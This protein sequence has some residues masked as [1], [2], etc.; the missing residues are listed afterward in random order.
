[1]T[2]NIELEFDHHTAHLIFDRKESSA[3][4][5]DAA[6]LEE[7]NERLT[8]IEE[9]KECDGLI[10][11][12]RKPNIFIAG[13]DLHSLQNTELKDLSELISLGQ[14]TFNRIA[15]LPFPTVAA[16][17]GACVGGGCELALAC[18]WRVATETKATKIGLPETQLGIIPAWGGTTRLPRLIG[19]PKALSIILPGKI[20]KAKAAKAK[21]LVDF[22]VPKERLKDFAIKLLKKDRIDRNQHTLTN[23]VIS[24]NI[25]EKKAKDDLLLK[26]KG[27]YPAQEEALHAAC[28]GIHLTRDESLHLERLAIE[29]LA[30]SETANNLMRIFFL[31][32]GSKKLRIGETKVKECHTPAVIGA[33]VMGSGIA[34]WLTSKG[35]PTLMKDVSLQALAKGEHTVEKLYQA[36]RKRRV[37]NKTEAQQGID[38][39]KTTHCEVPLK[40]YDL[41]I[42]AATEDLPIK[43]KIFENLS[44]KVSED[45]LLATN[46]SALP[47]HGLIDSVHNPERLVGLHFFNPVHRMQLVEVVKTKHVSDEFLAKAVNFVQKIGKLPVVVADSP[48]FLVNRVLLP[49]L[50]EAG[51]MFSRGIKP[52]FIDEAMLEFGMP[53]GPLRLLDEIGLDVAHHVAGTLSQAFPDRMSVPDILEQMIG[54][55]MLG[56]K[57]GSGFYTY[58]KGQQPSPNPKA[59]ELR[60]SDIEAPDNIGITLARLMALEASHCLDEGIVERPEDVDF[61]MIMGTGFAPFRGGPLRYAHDHGVLGRKFYKD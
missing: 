4:I 24:S 44:K 20:L 54:L 9:N 49:Y 15:E 28:Q 47:L 41:I 61:A 57:T 5:F 14:F 45:T 11:L 32:E 31:N 50:V 3:N 40:N 43:Q 35:Y 29:K 26:T 13:A 6:T 34:Y 51:L 12:S 60:A 17:H 58:K 23:N 33:G 37:F 53:M 8:A 59:L 36:A 18:D 25:I 30:K 1:M 42:E 52:H 55:G 27:H 19:L 21:G 38:R 7:L 56:K 16:I 10:I 2:N 39:L 46:T 48:G 22:L